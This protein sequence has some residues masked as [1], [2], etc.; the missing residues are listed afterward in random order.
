MKA[1][2]CIKTTVTIDLGDFAT[3]DLINEL[4]ERGHAVDADC[5][6]ELDTSD[7]L[8]ELCRRQ[9]TKQFATVPLHVLIGAL[10]HFG[11]PPDLIDRLLEWDITPVA[12][13]ATLTQWVASCQERSNY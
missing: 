1:E 10:K 8:E 12:T 6:A 5:A 3:R 11:C 13:E 9:Y 2:A 7:L 4:E